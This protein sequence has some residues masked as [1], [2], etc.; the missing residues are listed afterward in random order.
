MYLF[1]S[2]SWK[3][4]HARI[5]NTRTARCDALCGRAINST[6]VSPQTGVLYGWRERGNRVS[7][8]EGVFWYRRDRT[9][10]LPAA[11][12][13]YPTI[14]PLCPENRRPPRHTRRHWSRELLIITIP[15]CA[16][17]RRQPKICVLA[18]G[19]AINRQRV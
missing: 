7:V 15:Q 3:R 16:L 11:A 5:H 14:S 13:V 10:Y 9:I 12:R 1:R 2:E 18:A 19:G 17:A 8:G 6:L 4:I